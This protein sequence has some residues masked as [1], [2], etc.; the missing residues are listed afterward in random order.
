ML[1]R[2]FKEFLS[3]RH[4]GRDLNG[5]GSNTDLILQSYD[6][7]GDRVTPITRVATTGGNADPFAE[8]RD[9]VAVRADA[10]RCD[11]GVTCD[12]D[13]DTCGAGIDFPLDASP[14]GSVSALFRSGTVDSASVCFHFGGEIKQ[15]TQAV[16]GRT[17]SFKAS[18]APAP[19]ICPLP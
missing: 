7:C 13:A 19:S 11:L 14:Q 4:C 15:D 6:F 8:P 5:G 12:P 18:N 1:Q 2:R 16:D 3:Q 9:S 17:A 10:G